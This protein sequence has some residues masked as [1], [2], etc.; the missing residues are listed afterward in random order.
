MSCCLSGALS[1]IAEFLPLL[2]LRTALTQHMAALPGD[3]EL[4]PAR[5]QLAGRYRCPCTITFRLL[6]HVK[7][8][9]GFT[10]IS[11]RRTP[12]PNISARCTNIQRCFGNHSEENVLLRFRTAQL[13]S[14]Y[15]AGNDRPARPPRRQHCWLFCLATR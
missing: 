9:A 1:P 12:F 4:I 15:P 10:L 5:Q 13:G 7:P 2:P 14:R 11:A 3:P 6:C 8:T